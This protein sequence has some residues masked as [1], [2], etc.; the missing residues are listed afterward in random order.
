MIYTYLFLTF[1][2]FVPKVVMQ[3]NTELSSTQ[4]WT[5]R[6][7]LHCV[8]PDFTEKYHMKLLGKYQNW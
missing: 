1:S 4:E 7:F 2:M 3:F 8:L 5:P 6:Q